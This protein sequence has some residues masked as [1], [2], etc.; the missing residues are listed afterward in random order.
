MKRCREC[1]RE[2]DFDGQE[3]DPCK[4]EK[5]RL[6]DLHRLFRAARGCIAD[7]DGQEERIAIYQRRAIMR[8]PLFTEESDP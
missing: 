2:A 8:L 7:V 5:R 3:C 4:L 6:R 1:R